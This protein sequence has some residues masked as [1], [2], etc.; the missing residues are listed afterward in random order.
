MTPGLGRL[1]KIQFEIPYEESQQSRLKKSHM[2]ITILA[3][4]QETPGVPRS[5]KRR[6]GPSLEPWE[7]A[8]PRGTRTSESRPLESEPLPLEPPGLRSPLTA[9]SGNHETTAV[10][11]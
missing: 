2:L 8:W 5:W 9:A 3:T 6:E 10:V 1:L 11:R 7:G 4:N